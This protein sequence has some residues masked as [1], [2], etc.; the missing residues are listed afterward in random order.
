MSDAFLATP[1]ARR[2]KREEKKYIYIY[3]VYFNRTLKVSNA[4]S[5]PLK[6]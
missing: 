2:V 1:F 6:T 5:S 3:C 4:S